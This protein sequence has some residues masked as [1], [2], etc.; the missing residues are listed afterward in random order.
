MFRLNTVE[1]MDI[2]YYNVTKLR[3]SLERDKMRLDKVIPIPVKLRD[4]KRLVEKTKKNITS[5]QHKRET[6]FISA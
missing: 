1:R 6:H 4:E 3:L 2:L 5:E